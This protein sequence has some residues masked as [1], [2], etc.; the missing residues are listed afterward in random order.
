VDAR[1]AQGLAVIHL[2][3]NYVIAVLHRDGL[4]RQMRE[5]TMGDYIN[6]STAAWAEF[7]CGPIA[8]A[9]ALHARLLIDEIEPQIEADAQLAAEL[10]NR[11]GRRQRSLPDCLIAAAAIRCGAVLATMNIADFRRFEAFGLMLL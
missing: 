8:M 2:D 9:E 10:F 5:S 11:S 6:A 7:L 1:F 4:M 3:A